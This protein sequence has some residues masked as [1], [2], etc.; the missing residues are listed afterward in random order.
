M[1]NFKVKEYI[2]EKYQIPLEID[3]D[4]NCAALAENEVDSSKM[5]AVLY[6]GTGFGSAFIQNGMLIKGAYNFSGEIGHTPF[7]TTPFLCGCG[8]RDSEYTNERFKSSK[9]IIFFITAFLTIYYL[10]VSANNRDVA[11]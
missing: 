7:K 10:V 5:L 2:K 11:K 4:L 1:E 8:R 9:S 3:N 6:I